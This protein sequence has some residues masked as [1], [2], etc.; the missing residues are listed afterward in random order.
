MPHDPGEA[1]LSVQTGGAGTDAG[2]FLFVAPPI[3][4]ALS[5]TRG[6]AAGG[7]RVA[8]GGNNFRQDVTQ[9]LFGGAGL[10]CAVFVNENRIDGYTPPGTETVDVT[11]T[12]PIG[13][14]GSSNQRFVY[15][16]SL[17]SDLAPDAGCP[18]GG[19]GP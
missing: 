9:I 4:R 1:A 3:V 17:P 7:T 8:I 5:P 6:A 18:D 14:D 13:G 11:A 2:T 16:V 10:R 12:D 19:V 15:D